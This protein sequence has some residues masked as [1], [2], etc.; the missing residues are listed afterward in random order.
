MPGLNLEDKVE[1]ID[2]SIR[3]DDLFVRHGGN[4]LLQSIK[5]IVPSSASGKVMSDSGVIIGSTTPSAQGLE[6][7]SPA[8]ESIS[9]KNTFDITGVIKNSLITKVTIDNKEA[10]VSPVDST[11]IY[12]DFR[13]DSEINDLVYKGYDASNTIVSK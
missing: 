2:D 8:H 11:F 13:I 4:E 6:I 9:N 1:I 10:S 7:I 12:K 3:A 5:S